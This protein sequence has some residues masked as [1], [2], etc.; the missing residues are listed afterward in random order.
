MAPKGNWKKWGT[1]TSSILQDFLPINCR[2]IRMSTHNFDQGQN[3]Y[4]ITI[5]RNEYV[6][7]SVHPENF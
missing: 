5:L 6:S 3:D 7:P 2:Q 1:L 4:Y